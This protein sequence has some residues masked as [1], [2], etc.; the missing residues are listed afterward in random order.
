MVALT[1][2]EK[3]D[4]ENLSVCPSEKLLKIHSGVDVKFEFMQSN[5]NMVA[6][7]RTLGL[8]Q[9]ER[10]RSGLSAGYF[11]SKDR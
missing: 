3:N 9:N 7:K 11:P 2:G 8:D 1:D 5:G 10:G 6:K 4:Y